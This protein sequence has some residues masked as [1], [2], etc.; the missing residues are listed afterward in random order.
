M[1]RCLESGARR[2]K[3]LFKKRPRLAGRYGGRCEKRKNNDCLT[4]RSHGHASDP[5]LQQGHAIDYSA[6]AAWWRPIVGAWVLV[7]ISR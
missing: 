3:Y 4:Q 7:P 1:T 5:S 2:C 6:I